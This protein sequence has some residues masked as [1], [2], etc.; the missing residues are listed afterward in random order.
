MATVEALKN[1]ARQACKSRGHRMGAFRNQHTHRESHLSTC[2]DCGRWAQ[3]LPKP[4]SNEIDVCGP[5]VALKCP[6][7]GRKK[8][9]KRKGGRS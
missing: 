3:V 4:M 1:Q 6:H 9:M 8:T 2:I 5:A 7:P